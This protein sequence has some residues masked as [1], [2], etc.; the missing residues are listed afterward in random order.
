MTALFAG[1]EQRHRGD[2]DAKFL[3][4]GFIKQ[5]GAVLQIHPVIKVQQPGF[6]VRLHVHA[7]APVKGI[8]RRLACRDTFYVTRRAF[9][10]ILPN[11]ADMPDAL[12]LLAV[13]VDK[14][15]IQGQRIADNI[16]AIST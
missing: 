11:A 9:I 14:M 16:P 2:G 10:A 3:H 8:A 7:V 1:K 5:T 15:F 4:L 6:T 12:L 13:I